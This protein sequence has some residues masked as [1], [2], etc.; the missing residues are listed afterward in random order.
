M[1]FGVWGLGFGVW[2]L[3]FGV[4]GLGFGDW[5]L[6]IGVW[7]WGW[8]LG[9]GVWGLGFRVEGLLLGLGF[10]VPKPPNPKTLISEPGALDPELKTAH[11]VSGFRFRLW[12]LGSVG[13]VPVSARC[14]AGTLV[15]GV[16]QVRLPD[17]MQSY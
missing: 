13:H 7:G 5:G 17:P 9:F 15:G 11:W 4:W 12:G 2:G 16:L 10:G 14:Q 3:G 1:G 8:G 6:G